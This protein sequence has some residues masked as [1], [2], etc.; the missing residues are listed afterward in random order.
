VQDP[1]FI[2]IPAAK[3]KKKEKIWKKDERIS[4]ALRQSRVHIYVRTYKSQIKTKR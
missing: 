2:P 4:V 1:E 3:K